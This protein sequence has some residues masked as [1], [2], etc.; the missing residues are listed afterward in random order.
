VATAEGLAV[1]RSGG[2]GVACIGTVGWHPANR[3]MSAKAILLPTITFRP[4][5]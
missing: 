3:S 5:S 4:N 2:V 1:G